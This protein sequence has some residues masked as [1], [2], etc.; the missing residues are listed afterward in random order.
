MEVR[1][2]DFAGGSGTSQLIA[3]AD[4]L[5]RNHLDAREVRIPGL[6]SAAMIDDYQVAVLPAP[7]SVGDDTVGC[8]VDWGTWGRGEVD[9]S[10]HRAFTGE[11][12]CPAAEGAQETAI[13][14]PQGRANVDLPLSGIRMPLVRDRGSLQKIVFYEGLV[15]GRGELNVGDILC[16]ARLTFEAVGYGDFASEHLQGRE[17]LVLLVRDLL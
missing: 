16:V 9:A 17:L 10:V 4:L 15:E 1:R 13:E 12:V 2:R 5:A 14:G 7:G 3:S 11:G 6:H 8:D